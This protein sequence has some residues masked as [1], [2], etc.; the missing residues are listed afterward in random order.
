MAI[1]THC[2]RR[3]AWNSTLLVSGIFGIAAGGA[4]NFVTFC[5]L[6]AMTGFGVGGNM[7]VDGTL[8]LEFLPGNKQYLLTLLSVWWAI[9]QVVASLIAWGFLARWGCQTPPAGTFCKRED[10]MGWRY[11]YFTLGA[12]MIVLWALR[13]FVLPVYESPKFLAS[14]GRDADAVEVIHKIA[15]RNGVQ[16]DLTV[17]DLSRA[18]EPFLDD[19]ERDKIARGGTIATSTGASSWELFK[20]SFENLSWSHVSALFA[21]RRLATSTIL[22][23]F[24]YG[25]LGLA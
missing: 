1:L 25:S 23:T 8:F 6:I 22:I 14:V 11:T 24:C 18:A 5:A 15:R 19:K 12:M 4:N 16:V 2:S 3:L 13:F 10:N 21:T 9:G 17:E 20:H 7:P